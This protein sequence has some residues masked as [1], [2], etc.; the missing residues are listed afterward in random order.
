MDFYKEYSLIK[1]LV[2]SDLDWLE[3]EFANL[4]SEKNDLD[5]KLL[6]ILTTSAKRIRPLL[7]FLF[8]RANGIIPNLKMK[9]VLLAVELIHNA[10]LIHDD[11][12]DSASVRRGLTTINENFDDD[13]AVVAGDYVLSVAMEKIAETDSVQTVKIFA[14]AMK[15]TCGGEISQFFSKYKIQTISEYI[16]KSKLKTAILFELAMLAPLEFFE[17]SD[18]LKK[19]AKDFAY[20]FGIA[21]QIRDDLINFKNTKNIDKSDFDEGIYTAPVILADC[22]EDFEKIKT[23]G[24]IE[25]TKDLLDN[26]LD[27]AKESLSC[28]E[29]NVYKSAIVDIIN[30]LK[31][32][33]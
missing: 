22:G 9:K 19:V 7:G 21:F 16:E 26:Y 10:S 12:I 32:S 28:I 27:K 18:K 4:F 33:V 30:L 25:K 23:C 13:L 5:T 6:T 17:N 15:K 1:N 29:E 24:S 14:E 8:L 2:A 20:N 3:A 11:V 31:K